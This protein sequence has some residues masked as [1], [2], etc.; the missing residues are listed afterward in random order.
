MLRW[1]CSTL[2]NC[3]TFLSLGL[4][5][6]SLY[7]ASCQ[8]CHTFGISNIFPSPV[9]SRLHLHNVMSQSH[10]VTIETFPGLQARTPCLHVCPHSLF[11]TL[12]EDSIIP[13]LLHPSWL[14]G[15]NHMDYA[16]KF[17]HLLIMGPVFFLDLHFH[18]FWFIPFIC[19]VFFL[20]LAIY[21]HFPLASWKLNWVRSCP[22]TALPLIH[23]PS[24]LSLNYSSLWAQHLAP[25]LNF[26]VFFLLLKMDILS[27]F[28]Y[29]TCAL[30]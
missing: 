13:L 1:L 14:K 7:S 15:Q 20:S 9:K 29:P 17:C 28:L 21:R 27:F 4:V 23:F 12:E 25:T 18:K 11:L 5:S 26:L 8:I 2:F 30:S 6:L 22:G 24:G 3:N 10:N 19:W 16:A